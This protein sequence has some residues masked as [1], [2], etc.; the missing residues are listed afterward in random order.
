MNRNPAEMAL[1]MP[2]IVLT[3]REKLLLEQHHG[4]YS[5]ETNRIRVRTRQGI[6]TVTGNGLVISFFGT[7]DLQIEGEITGIALEEKCP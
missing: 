4:L 5:Y 2:R 3:G 6:V 1:R 7:E